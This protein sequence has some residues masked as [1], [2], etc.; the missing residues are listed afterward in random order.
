M[1]AFAQTPGDPKELDVSTKDAWMDTGLDLRPA[2]V[3]TIS[4]SGT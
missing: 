1:A 4:A 2:D 3:L